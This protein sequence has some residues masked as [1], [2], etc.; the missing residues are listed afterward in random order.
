MTNST[1]EDQGCTKAKASLLFGGSFS[2]MST[3]ESSSNKHGGDKKKDGLKLKRTV[4]NFFQRTSA[5]K[6]LVKSIFKDCDT[7]NSGEVGEDE[8]YVGLLLVHLN[9]VKM[10][11]GAACFPPSRE[12]VKK[13]FEA[14][15]IDN[16]GS[17][18]EE[19]FLQILII[20]S[21][22]VF[23]RIGL[24]LLFLLVIVP[25]IAHGLV[26]YLASIL[27]DKEWFQVIFHLV[28]DPVAKV[29]WLDEMLD[30]DNIVTALFSTVIF[31]ALIARVFT[32]IDV[33]YQNAAE[34]RYF[35]IGEGKEKESY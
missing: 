29:E 23:S 32:A 7:S 5:F 8:L 21:G 18:D 25:T 12:A 16:S 2:K 35:E 3:P 31:S 1:K 15:D 4:G 20:C 6:A 9:L 22:Q 19:E 27:M 24:Y 33:F 34:K 11:G 13:L 30:W 26:Q 28:Q 14:S 17:I 10:V